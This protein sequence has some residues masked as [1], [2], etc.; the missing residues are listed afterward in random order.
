MRVTLIHNPG[1][2]GKNASAQAL[3]A[4][5][6]AAG[7]EVRYQSAKDD[8]WALALEHEAE[9]IAVAGGDGTVSRVVKRVVGRGVPLAPLPCGTANNISRALGIVGVPLEELVHSWPHARRARLDVGVARGPWGT[10]YFVEGIGIGLLA[11]TIA[12]ADHNKTL[13]ALDRNDAKLT[14]AMQMLKDRLE[15]CVPTALEATLDGRR[16]A[17]RFV[18]FEALNIPF[19]GPN[20]FLAPDSKPGDGQL[21][22]VLVTEAECERVREYLSSWQDEKP[23]VAVLPSH[24]GRN[25]RLEWTGFELHIDDQLWPP[26]GRSCA[27][28]PAT[29]EVS[30]ADEGVEVLVGAP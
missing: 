27:E 16:I 10:R 14:Y 26:P 15:S 12:D 11:R 2:G 8:N 28:P 29:I 9:L 22:L 30:L 5:L 21:D 3:Q 7:H 6:A 1:A 23:R 19:V 13:S 4:L 25:L 20:L 24:R 17:G 18:L